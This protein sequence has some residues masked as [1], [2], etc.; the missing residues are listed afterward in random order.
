MLTAVFISLQIILLCIITLHDWIHVPPFT[1][2]RELEKHHSFWDRFI[3]SAI[4]GSLVLIP[5]LLTWYYQTHYPRWVLIVISTMYAL[6]TLGTILA[7]WIP[8]FFGSSE[9]HKQG[10]IEYQNT[11]H[12]LPKRGD[13]VVPNTFHVCMHVLIWTCLLLSISLLFKQ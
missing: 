12:F 5:L 13:N 4:N 2:I 8:Y 1:N 9:Q 6:L 7:W 3:T 11:H 10:F